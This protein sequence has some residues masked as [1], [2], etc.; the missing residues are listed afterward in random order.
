MQQLIRISAYA[1]PY[2]RRVVLSILCALFVSAFWSLNLSITFPIVRVLFEGDNLHENVDKEIAELKTEISGY[3][4]IL[5]NLS[6]SQI[7]ERARYQ[8]KLNDASQVLL[9]RQW[10][11]D[12]I[13]PF[14]PSD[15]FQTVM[16]ILALIVFASLM[17]GVFV[18]IQE[19]LVGGLVNA[20]SNDIRSD[21]FSS[22]VRL[23]TQTLGALGTANLTSRLTNDVTEVSLG[24]RLFGADLI[25]EPLKALVCVAVAF[26]FNWR[27]TLVGML[28]LPLIGVLFHK[29]GKSLRKS[30]KQSL[31]TMSGIYRCISETFDSIR[32]VLA[33]GGEKKHIDQ[34]HEANTEYYDRSMKLVR[35]TALVRPATELLG[36]IAFISIL[37]P[38]AYMVLNQT[39]EIAGVKLA[40]R[41]LELAE[42]ATLYAL[43]AGILDPLRKMSGIL[44]IMRRS[45]AASERVFEVI[46]MK[47]NVPEPQ[48]PLVA[49]RHSE[50]ISFEDLSFHYQ[51]ADLSSPHAL[52][53]Q[54]VNLKVRFGEVVAVVGSNGCGKSTLTSLIPRLMDPT[55]GAV[56][57]DGVDVRQFSLHDL[58]AQ[59]GVVTQDTMLF[60]D[61]V[62]NNIRYGNPDADHHAIEDAIR[63]S[64][65]ADF[66]SLLPEGMNT[67]VGAK[68]QR[69]SGG[70][71]QRISLARAIVRDPSILILDEATSAIDAESETLIYKA[72]RQFTR[73][74][75][76]FIISHVLNHHFLDLIDRV[77]VMDKGRIVAV[78][79]HE[80]LSDSCPE[81]SRLLQ[82][83][84]TGRRAA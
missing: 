55:E 68:G 9:M 20:A 65:A 63:L 4:G 44:P 11:K 34:L 21:V 1:W 78:G 79:S 51:T 82:D 3:E 56:R 26:Y 72:L 40:S 27:L 52:A 48:S 31:E 83:K 29:S 53:L 49:V 2:R 39:D 41:P 43:L 69:L 22:A 14:V 5:G 54:A 80:E 70:Q 71:K 57:I 37:I 46:D 64:H 30:S 35:V 59:I 24:L 45:I 50:S 38:G 28:V 75:T 47:T 10:V 60:D 12:L 19:I 33:F 61:T 66:L 6:E 13:L 17:K 62:Y 74:R 32:V 81:Y 15:R 84:P 42:L 8:R 76:T 16:L 18:Y 23:D 67:R 7:A 36:I 58:R 73:G 77:V 25:R